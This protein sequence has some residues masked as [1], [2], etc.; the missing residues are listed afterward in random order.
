MCVCLCV[1][2]CVCVYNMHLRIHKHINIDIEIHSLNYPL[3]QQ[4]PLQL[5]FAGNSAIKHS[6]GE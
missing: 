4:R 6:I 3:F 2:I 5:D 1:C